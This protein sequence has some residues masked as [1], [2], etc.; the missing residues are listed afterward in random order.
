MPNELNELSKK[1]RQELIGAMSHSGPAMRQL[2][3]QEY[4]RAAWAA[5]P[6]AWGQGPGDQL[7]AMIDASPIGPRVRSAAGGGAAGLAL[8]GGNPYGGLLG[9]ALSQLHGVHPEIDRMMD[10][11]GPGVP[12]GAMAI[13]GVGKVTKAAAAGTRMLGE[14]ELW[15]LLPKFDK[16]T[17]KYAQRFQTT[18][19]DAGVDE[20][21]TVVPMTILE[22]IKDKGLPE[23]VNLDAYLNTIVKRKT[24][25][26]ANEKAKLQGKSLVIGEEVTDK[27]GVAKA[28]DVA[29]NTAATPERILQTKQAPTV[30]EALAAPETMD[31]QRFIAALPKDQALSKSE[32]KI[33]AKLADGQ[34]Y[35][36][37]QRSLGVS[38]KTV[39]K[40]NKALSGF[41]S[42]TPSERLRKEGWSPKD[43]VEAVDQVALGYGQKDYG[44]LSLIGKDYLAN[45]LQVADLR[46]KYGAGPASGLRQ[47]DLTPL[48]TAAA[49]AAKHQHQFKQSQFDRR[50]SMLVNDVREVLQNEKTLR[51]R[52]IVFDDWLQKTAKVDRQTFE[53]MPA[54]V[55]QRAW[56]AFEEAMRKR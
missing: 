35:T 10:A 20:T 8:S 28:L 12:L 15:E 25:D 40:V 2:S 26:F 4:L 24:F 22:L 13:P 1:Y 9:M 51:T 52:N 50:L 11:L 36:Q 38:A 31:L 18:I 32:K 47:S 43:V 23:D 46:R 5:G 30:P 45:N 17:R 19:G 39:A 56:Q 55:K 41:E 42:L 16:L 48:P 34:S 3:P 29:D 6:S 53:G 44:N 21:A 54:A 14:E 37:I 33:A 49:D 7:N 27:K